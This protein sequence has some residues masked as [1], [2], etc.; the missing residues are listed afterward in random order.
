MLFP[1]PTCP[2][3]PSGLQGP[4]Q[5]DTCDA[6]APARAPA[7]GLQLELGGRASSGEQPAGLGLQRSWDRTEHRSPLPAQLALRGAT[8]TSSGR[9]RSSGAGFQYTSPPSAE[10]SAAPLERG[11]QFPSHGGGAP[12]GGLQGSER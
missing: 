10:T 1:V 2:P 3:H 6:R 12:V 9:Q 8:R 4:G 7:L 11:L 5:G